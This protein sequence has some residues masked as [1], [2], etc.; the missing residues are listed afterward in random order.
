MSSIKVKITGSILISLI[1]LTTSSIFLLSI[2]ELSGLSKFITPSYKDSANSL[3][4]NDYY[5]NNSITSDPY[6]PFMVQHL[7][8]FYLFSLPWRQ[9]DRVDKINEIVSIDKD[10]FRIN[11]K[12]SDDYNQSAV[13]LGGSTAF[14]HF[15]SSDKTTIAATLSDIMKINVYNR[16]APSWNSH[17][18]L[19]ALVKF[20]HNYDFSI[21]FSL[22][23]DISVACFENSK[24]FEGLNYIDAP[25]SFINLANKVNDIRGAYK[26]NN[27]IKTFFIRVFPDT[28]MLLGTLKNKYIN[29]VN[30]TSK[31]KID[32]EFCESIN[33]ERIAISFLKNQNTMRLLSEARGANHV[34][35]LQPHLD[36]LDLKSYMSVYKNK[37]YDI[38]ID[39]QYCKIYICLDSRDIPFELKISDLYDGTNLSSAIFADGVHLLDK[40][41][42][43]YS[44][45]LSKN[46][47]IN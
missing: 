21:S 11:P 14:G 35:V 44:I 40:G 36:L 23:N 28:Y 17:Q 4:Q 9:S 10:G 26:S 38:I 45:F 31:N 32:K 34:V 29:N 2:I 1:I 37:V 47:K 8:P 22:S 42:I 6:A 5:K 24:W 13:L 3:V 15:S 25:E 39:S 18:E 41:V 12:N 16:N 30:K 27:S 33:P 19:I 20:N 46:L 43:K 7:H